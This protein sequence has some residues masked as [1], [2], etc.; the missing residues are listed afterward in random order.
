V[1]KLRLRHAVAWNRRDIGEKPG[2][3]IWCFTFRDWKPDPE[4]MA[5]RTLCGHTIT[6]RI[7]SAKLEKPTCPD[8][9]KKLE[10]KR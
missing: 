2:E 10:E 5:D 4:A 6:F 9:I 8:C 3:A 7:G 1:S